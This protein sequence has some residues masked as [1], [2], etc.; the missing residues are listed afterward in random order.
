MHSNILVHLGSLGKS[1]TRDLI[2]SIGLGLVLLATSASA[3]P[4]ALVYKGPG[5]CP[6]QCSESAALMAE[7]QGFETVMVG[8]GKPDSAL[9]ARAELYIQP[10][11]LGYVVADS[12]APEMKTAI[13]E[14]VASGKAYVG[15]CAGGFFATETFGKVKFR[16]GLG[17]LPGHSLMTLQFGENVEVALAKMIWNGKPRTLYWETGPYFDETTTR[18][19]GVEKLATYP[20]GTVATLRAPFGKGRVI[21]TGVHPEA[22]QSWFVGDTKN[23]PDGLD[24]D[25]AREMIAWATGQAPLL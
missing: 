21:V 12:M 9:F 22:P 3:K 17:L 13:R 10:G 24:W 6:E 8:P 18:D 2:C 16:V 14:F 1:R 20:D 19:P 7:L 11:G 15:F 25:L 4:L 5:A 23:D